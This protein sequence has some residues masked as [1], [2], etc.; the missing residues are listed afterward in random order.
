MYTVLLSFYSPVSPI[1]WPYSWQSSWWLDGY[2][3]WNCS[4]AM[5]QVC[6]CRYTAAPLLCLKWTVENNGMFLLPGAWPGRGHEVSSSDSEEFICA[7]VSPI[8]RNTDPVLI[9]WHR[10][11][12]IRLWERADI[13]YEK[14]V[15]CPLL[16]AQRSKFESVLS[17]WIRPSESICVIEL[18]FS[19]RWCPE[20]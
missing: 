10:V 1:Y 9:C 16:I 2:H 5:W 18:I 4:S 12:Q 14:M 11:V 3:Q 17:S 13:M 8:P 15:N 20:I 6:A 19:S 7:K